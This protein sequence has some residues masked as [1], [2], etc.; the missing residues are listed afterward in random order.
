MV[1][2]RSS[3]V[4]D[5]WHDRCSVNSRSIPMWYWR[6]ADEYAYVRWAGKCSGCGLR[7]QSAWIWCLA[8]FFFFKAAGDLR[9]HFPGGRAVVKNLPADAGDAGDVGSIPQSGRS[10]GEGN[11]NPLQYSCLGNPMDRGT[12]WVTVYGVARESDT[13]WQLNSK[14]ILSIKWTLSL[15]YW[16]TY[17][18]QLKGEIYQPV[19]V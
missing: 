8:I 4:P 2:V 10:P 5:A 12:W 1:V 16:S 13:T 18:L 15:K 19:F 3:P 7:S 6:S 17:I 11:G 9:F 14:Q